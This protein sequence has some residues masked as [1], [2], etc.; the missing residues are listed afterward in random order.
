MEEHIY[1]YTNKWKSDENIVGVVVSGSYAT[2]LHTQNSDI[3][4]RIIF[5]DDVE[6]HY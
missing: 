2:K 4:L 6:I 5:L 3:D 1:E